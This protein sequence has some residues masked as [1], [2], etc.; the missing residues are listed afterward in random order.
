LRFIVDLRHTDDGVE[1]E[2]TPE[3]ATEPQRFSGW[4]EL[5]QLLEPPAVGSTKG[6]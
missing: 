4:L 3:G 1:G 6:P 2:V 5:L